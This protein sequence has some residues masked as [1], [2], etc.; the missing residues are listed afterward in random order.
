MK[1]PWSR[2]T[3]PAEFLTAEQLYKL[4]SGSA[5]IA[6]SLDAVARAIEL[7]SKPKPRELEPVPLI[8]RL[9]ES[10]CVTYNFVGFSSYLRRTF[11][12]P[13]W[14]WIE[15][16]T[17]P[18]DA[19][20][21]VEVSESLSGRTISQIRV[22][23]GRVPIVIRREDLP[24]EAEFRVRPRSPNEPYRLWIYAHVEGAL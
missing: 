24:S 4:Q 15:I 14:D 3:K 21:N 23:P 10:Y 9:G 1:W 13:V 5:R 12:P 20:E 22:R 2:K 6:S 16:E 17:D 11:C 7:L 8:V 18:I 19:I